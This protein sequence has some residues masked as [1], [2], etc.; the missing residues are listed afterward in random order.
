MMPAETT[1]APIVSEIESTEEPTPADEEPEA[2]EATSAQ[3]EPETLK[4]SES[5]ESVAPENVE[6]HEKSA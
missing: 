6:P 5:Q 3:S 4:A 2:G 1:D